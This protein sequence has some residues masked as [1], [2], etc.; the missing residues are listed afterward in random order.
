MIIM[1]A[2][3]YYAMA[4]RIGRRVEISV[5]SINTDPS[6]HFQIHTTNCHQQMSFDFGRTEKDAVRKIDK[7]G[8]ERYGRNLSDFYYR[9]QRMEKSTLLG[10][11]KTS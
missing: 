8:R 11:L 5:G 10:P 2:N 7:L 1:K 9:R 6:S 4:I 3:L